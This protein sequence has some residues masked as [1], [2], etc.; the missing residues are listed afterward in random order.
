MRLT[1]QNT[2]ASRAIMDRFPRKNKIC[3]SR[4]FSLQAQPHQRL[5]RRIK[6]TP[7]ILANEELRQGFEI[8]NNAR[9][10]NSSEHLDNELDRSPKQKSPPGTPPSLSSSS[11]TASASAP[12]AHDSNIKLPSS[13][14]ST[15]ASTSTAA[16]QSSDT[17]RNGN[18]SQGSGENRRRKS[19][20]PPKR[21][22]SNSNDAAPQYEVIRPP[23]RRPCPDPEKFLH[24]IKL[25]KINLHRSPELNSKLNVKQKKRLIK[26]KERHFQ[27]LGLQRVSKVQRSSGSGSGI[28]GTAGSSSENESDDNEDFVPTQKISNVGRPSVTLRMRGQKDIVIYNKHITKA[29]KPTIRSD[30]KSSSIKKPSSSSSSSAISISQANATASAITSLPSAI[31][32]QLDRRSKELITRNPEISLIS[33]TKHKAG[34]SAAGS[35]ARSRLS[36]QQQQQHSSL[37]LNHHQITSEVTLSIR[38][39]AIDS[40]VCLCNKV[41]KF[42]TRKTDETYCSAVDQIEDQKV[43]C[44]NEV[45]GELLNLLRPSVRVSYMLLCESHKKR[46]VSHNCCASCGVFLTQGTF[47][48]CAKNHFFHRDCATKLI[49]NAPFDPQN[50]EYT[51]PTLVL[52]CPHC[53]CDAPER[54]TI[55]TMRCGSVPI[56]TTSQKKLTKPAKMSIGPHSYRAI[57]SREEL[58][59]LEIEHLIPESVLALL[60]RAQNRFPFTR[61]GSPHSNKDVFTAVTKDDVD[62][63]AEIV[64]S[65]FDIST[66]IKEFYNGTCLHLVSNFGSI[67]MTQL[68]LSR[69]ASI[70]F[71]NLLDQNLRTAIMC[72]IFGNKNDIL[73][74]LVQCGAD[75]TVKVGGHFEQFLNG[76][77]S[78]N[79]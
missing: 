39:E 17:N 65:G 56:F 12:L 71:L 5:S 62:R 6:P 72:A 59:L 4:F 66:P 64:A 19:N 76:E 37:D 18:N 3:F 50:P 28:V 70:D 48:L 20:T 47:M 67:R 23:V 30:Q 69:V 22:S 8:Q 16:L 32:D 44:G 55:V 10:S 26:L 35:S 68:I 49:L 40:N 58:H 31:I 78:E 63:M 7:K 11:S 77:K 53:N 73:K 21:Q 42:Y 38:K 41:S 43:G 9:L 57:K 79:S 2:V 1:I 52:K 15:S 29:T 24:E 75:V 54:E 14:A 60:T 45:E 25:A 46:L 34:S 74:L 51:C 36:Y 61:Q 33:S 13:I 27:K